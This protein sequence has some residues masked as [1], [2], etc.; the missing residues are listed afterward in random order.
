VSL[1]GVRLIQASGDMVQLSMSVAGHNPQSTSAGGG[2]HASYTLSMRVEPGT[3]SVQS[4]ELDPPIIDITPQVQHAQQHA[5]GSLQLLVSLVR[6]ALHG[7]EASS[8]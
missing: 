8:D 4:A 3:D 1:T 5:A 2:Q 7:I 6:G